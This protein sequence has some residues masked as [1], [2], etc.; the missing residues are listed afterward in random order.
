VSESGMK[1]GAD[2]HALRENGTDPVLIGETL[3][4]SPDKREA[5][6]KLRAG[7]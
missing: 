3:M 5:I 4:R 2:I 1:P 6:A 7:I